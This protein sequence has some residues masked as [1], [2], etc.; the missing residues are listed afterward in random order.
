M[1]VQAIL[2][3]RHAHVGKL[4]DIYAHRAQLA[5]Q[6][7]E[8]CAQSCAPQRMGG[9]EHSV[10]SVLLRHGY[11]YCARGTVALHQQMELI[12]VRRSASLALLQLFSPSKARRGKDDERAA[13]KGGSI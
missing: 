12:R 4:M 7:A 2:R 9:E 6:L 3:T 10:H 8:L 13:P 11:L 5:R 1:Q